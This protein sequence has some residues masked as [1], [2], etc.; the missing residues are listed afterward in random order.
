MNLVF[1]MDGIICTPCNDYT[2]VEKARP[3]ANVREFMIWL[4]DNNHQIT[5][6]CKR[7][8]SLDWVMATKDWLK[9][10]QIPYDR[11]LFEK[12][13]NPVMVSETPP[14]AK[15]YK[16]DNDLSIVAGLFEDWKENLVRQSK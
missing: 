6:W 9:V 14:N 4:T 3:L 13:Y 2:E 11:V 7:P 16:H 8:N 10:N 1:G 12:P 15:Y 5:I